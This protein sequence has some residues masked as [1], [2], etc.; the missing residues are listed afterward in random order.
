MD[1]MK[2]KKLLKKLYQANLENNQDKL[3]TLYQREIENI[4]EKKKAGKTRFS[5]KWFV[6]DE[7]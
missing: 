7:C 3:K 4:L 5:G 1:K 6:T 2:Q